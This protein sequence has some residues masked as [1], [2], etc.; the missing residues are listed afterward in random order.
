[1]PAAPGAP[2]QMMGG[3]QRFP[4]QQPQVMMGAPQGQMPNPMFM[5]GQMPGGQGQFPPGYRGGN[6]QYRQ[7][8]G[9]PG[10]PGGPP[11]MVGG[12]PQMFAQMPMGG[13]PGAMNM[14]PGAMGLGGPMPGGG[15]GGAPPAK[16]EFPVHS[17]YIGNLSPKTF[18]LDL[19]KFFKSRGYAIAGVKVM[20]SKESRQ[21]RGYGYLN[22]YAAEEAERCLEGM[23]NAVIDGK[24]IVLSKKKDKDFDSKANVLVKNLPKE[25]DQN[26]LKKLFDEFGT[27]KSAKLEVFASG[28]S[29]GFGYVQFET[30]ESAR[31]AIAKLHGTEH[32]GSKL[33]VLPHVKKDER[34]DV[35]ENY[36]NLFVQNLPQ[37]YTDA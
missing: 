32:G 2:N 4:H 30:P 8:A 24:Q 22:F 1:M 14:G 7:K 27:I 16:R 6:Q 33:D 34:E 31:D 5:Q 13:M 15:P 10:F 17:L 19:Y 37:D 26:A 23:N 9:G 35:G 11:Q 18:D 21:S 28:E 12:G 3:Q 36:T 29:R 25:M 20:F